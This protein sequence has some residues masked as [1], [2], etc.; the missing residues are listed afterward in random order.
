MCLVGRETTEVKSHSI[1]SFQRLIL[2]TWLTTV[3][4][5]LYHLAGVVFIGFL[6]YKVFFFLFTI[7]YSLEELTIYSPHLRSRELWSI[8][9]REEHLDKSFGILLYGIFSCF[10][11]F[12]QIF[13]YFYQYGHMDT[14]FILWVLT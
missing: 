11:P 13:I 2:S 3:I 10:L 9:L 5:D 7:T 14:H 6:H 4:I 8:S 1:T 12:V